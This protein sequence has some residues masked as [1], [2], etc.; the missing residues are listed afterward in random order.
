MVTPPWSPRT[1]HDTTQNQ[2]KDPATILNLV[3][4]QYE[5]LKTQD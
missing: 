3:V 4:C 5:S 2:N 1:V